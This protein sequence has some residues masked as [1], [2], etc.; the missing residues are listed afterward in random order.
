MSCRCHDVRGGGENAHPRAPSEAEVG[1]QSRRAR[2][3]SPAP[4]DFGGLNH[5]FRTKDFV[6]F[7]QTLSPSNF[8]THRSPWFLAT[9]RFYSFDGQ[10]GNA[11]VPRSRFPVLTRSSRRHSKL[12]CDSCAKSSCR[13]S[14]VHCS[15]RERE[16]HRSGAAVSRRSLRD[17]PS[18]GRKRPRRGGLR[19]FAALNTT[20]RDAQEPDLHGFLQWTKVLRRSRH[21]TREPGPQVR[22]P[23]ARTRSATSSASGVPRPAAMPAASPVAKAV[24]I[25][26]T[27]P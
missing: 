1:C 11:V 16:G 6:N 5:P 21:R 9:P 3:V 24:P 15:R 8:M 22:P 27:D 26:R 17:T 13:P 10:H 14:R 23:R 25:T 2:S 19:S 4:F 7:T 20:V 18:A 12:G